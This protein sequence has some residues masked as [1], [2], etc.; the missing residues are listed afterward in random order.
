M[1]GSTEFV[2]NTSLMAHRRRKR[3][4]GGPGP[5][6]TGG[7]DGANPEP[8]YATSAPAEID[9]VAETDAI[10]RAL[11][12]L[13]PEERTILVLH[14]VDER[15]VAEIARTLGIPEGTA[16]SRLHAARQAAPAAMKVEA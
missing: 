16:K 2:A 7:R 15:P 14:H 12:H 4:R 10:S 1:A 3:R 11:A 13:R 9:A 6:D 8:E 5:P